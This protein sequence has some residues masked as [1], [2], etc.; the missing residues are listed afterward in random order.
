MVTL[1]YMPNIDIYLMVYVNNTETGKV[2]KGM[3]RNGGVVENT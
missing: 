2:M 1:H 3:K